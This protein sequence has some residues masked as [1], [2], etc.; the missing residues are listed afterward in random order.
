MHPVAIS[1]S[2]RQ[3]YKYNCTLRPQISPF[4]EGLSRISVLRVD[5]A[6]GRYDGRIDFEKDR[7]CGSE[8]VTAHLSDND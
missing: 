4:H 5:R 7:A 8:A 1:P 2:V 6:Q 3:D